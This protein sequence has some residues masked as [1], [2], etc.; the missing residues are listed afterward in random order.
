MS[1]MDNM[2]ATRGTG[3]MIGMGSAGARGSS[4]QGGDGGGTSVNGV[5]LTAA[6][7]AYRQRY[8]PAAINGGDEKYG[9]EMTNV[10][11]WYNSHLHPY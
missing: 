4:I 6:E 10:P 5:N 7:L 8:V 2:G 1:G 3:N 11:G 9:N